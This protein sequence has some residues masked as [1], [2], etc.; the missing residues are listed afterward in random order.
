MQDDIGSAVFEVE[1]LDVAV[2]HGYVKTGECLYDSLF[3][4]EACGEM[5]CGPGF[6]EAVFLFG[7]CE[8]PVEEVFVCEFFVV[9]AGYRDYVRACEDQLSHRFTVCI[10][11]L[12]SQVIRFLAAVSN[13][14]RLCLPLPAPK[15]K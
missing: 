15:S 6:G 8:T 3:S 7:G 5:L 4:G 10:R 13:L 12:V 14:P 9:E 1:Y 2:V 11:R